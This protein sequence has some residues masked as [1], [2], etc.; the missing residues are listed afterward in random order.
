M[1]AAPVVCP[2]LQPGHGASQ[3]DPGRLRGHVASPGPPALRAGRWGRKEERKRKEKRLNT[4]SNRK[5]SGKG[6][7]KLN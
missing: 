6:S 4:S 7:G 5:G 1:G 2:Y 3:G